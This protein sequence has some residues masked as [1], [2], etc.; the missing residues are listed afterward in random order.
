MKTVVGHGMSLLISSTFLLKV[1]I[2][3]RSSVEKEKRKTS[4]EKLMEGFGC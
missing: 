3:G 1:V 2:Y 4:W